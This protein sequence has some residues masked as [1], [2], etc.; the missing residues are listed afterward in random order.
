MFQCE[1]LS[2]KGQEAMMAHSETPARFLNII[3]FTKFSYE[4]HAKHFPPWTYY[5]IYLTKNFLE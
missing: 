5:K 3:K 1:I 2:L 4:S